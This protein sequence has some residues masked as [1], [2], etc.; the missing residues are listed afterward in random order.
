[1][2]ATIKFNNDIAKITN[3]IWQSENKF[4]E[5]TLNDFRESLAGMKYTI[6]PDHFD[7]LDAKG[8]VE[9]LGGNAEII[10]SENDLPEDDKDEFVIH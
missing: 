7:S 9:F 4:L 2:S 1:M 8:A 5:A 6:V 10:F 3:G